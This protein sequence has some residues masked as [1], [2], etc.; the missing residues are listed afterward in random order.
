MQA[1]FM[2]EP[3][4]VADND[5]VVS[6]SFFYTYVLAGSAESQ[7]V[8]MPALVHPWARAQKNSGPARKT[9]GRGRLCTST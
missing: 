7:P 6:Q 4:C 8:S 9:L 1:T 3:K 2:V 5:F